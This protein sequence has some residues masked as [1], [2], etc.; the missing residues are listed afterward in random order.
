M[1]LLIFCH[2]ASSGA[3]QFTSEN[4]DK[5]IA[6]TELVF[7]NFYADWCHFSNMLSPVWD[8]AADLVTE[9]LGSD[10]VVLG[11]VDC[12]QQDSIASR[13]HISKYPT[14]KLLRNGHPAKREYRGQRS[15]EAFLT[16]LEEELRDP[17][18]VINSTDDIK[19]EK[20]G[21]VIGYF[22]SRE[23]TNYR[24][25]EKMAA[26]LK[27][28]CHVLAGFGDQF[29]HMRPAG[30]DAVMVRK[31]GS[32]EDIT[33][34]ALDIMNTQ[35]LTD[36]AQRACVPLVR[37]ITF[38]NAEELTEERLPFMI[39][40]HKPDDT[41][42][43]QR[44]AKVVE[45]Q[46]FSEKEGINF[47]TADGLQ[48]AHPLHHLG[49]SKD[50]LPLI[51]IDSFRHMYVF[52]DIKDMETPGKL[53]QFIDDLHSGKLHREFHYGPQ[54]PAPAVPGTH[55]TTPPPTSPPESV[56][57]KLGPSQNRYSLLK[58]EL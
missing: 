32:T 6:S 15:A 39:L 11:K 16:F 53:K 57:K 1:L 22:D 21:Q 19:Q 33:H 5:T 27:D 55:P 14:L 20:K 52:P 28:E 46:L 58:D 41:E 12:D 30:E 25:F 50:D 35:K 4:F 31:A 49:K 34:P 2:G 10:R 29:R 42:T 9:K 7:V 48:F 43:P 8:K 47:L 38:S 24:S 44:Y 18:K 54:T 40:F 45:Q 13:F 17:V 23:S 36:W 37:E 56:F 51:A 3:V 26:A